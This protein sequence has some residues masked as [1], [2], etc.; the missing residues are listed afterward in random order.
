[1]ASL[2]NLRSRCSDR[3]TLYSIFSYFVCSEVLCRAKRTALSDSSLILWPFCDY[4]RILSHKTINPTSFT[5]TGVTF[6]TSNAQIGKAIISKTLPWHNAYRSQQPQ[7]SLP[8]YTLLTCNMLQEDSA[9]CASRQV[10]NFHSFSP[11]LL[12]GLG[13]QK[14]WSFVLLLYSRYLNFNDQL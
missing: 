13:K 8:H 9:F 2:E 10:C 1:M 12:S 11:P 5:N 7:S 14:H 3:H 4:T 6:K